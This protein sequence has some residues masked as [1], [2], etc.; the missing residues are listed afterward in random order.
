MRAHV[1]AL[2]CLRMC[3]SVY[4]CACALLADVVPIK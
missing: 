4:A 1:C 3:V 2:V